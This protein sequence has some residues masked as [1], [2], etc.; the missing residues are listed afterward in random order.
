MFGFLLLS[1]VAPAHPGAQLGHMV[2]E[3]ENPAPHARVTQMIYSGSTDKEE[4]KQETWL[5][6]GN[7]RTHMEPA[8]PVTKPVPPN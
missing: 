1:S 3:A 6:P 4:R 8:A 5:I 7:R 2:F